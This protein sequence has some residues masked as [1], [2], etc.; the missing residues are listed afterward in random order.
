MSNSVNCTKDRLTDEDFSNSN[1]CQFK[2]IPNDKI[3]QLIDRYFCLDPESKF[4]SIFPTVFS[5]EMKISNQQLISKE[6]YEKLV[7][8]KIS[9]YNIERMI[10]CLDE[11]I[12]NSLFAAN[13][14]L[15]SN[16]NL[17]QD[18][19]LKP[20]E[21]RLFIGQ[22]FNAVIVRDYNGL[23]DRSSQRKAFGKE[24]DSQAIL[25]SD[26]SRGAGVGLHIV[27]ELSSLL[28]FRQKPKQWTESAAFFVKSC[29]ALAPLIFIEV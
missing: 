16:K 5:W 18:Q 28:I 22:D 24:I 3:I 8:K 14:E 11:F 25:N 19:E 21:I 29:N 27:R 10:H 7:A 15:K 23:F 2:E 13:P 12:S 9:E 1:Y 4:E 6:I 26:S 20:I 17:G